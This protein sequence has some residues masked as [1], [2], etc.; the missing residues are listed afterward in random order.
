MRVMKFFPFR[1]LSQQLCHNFLSDNL[2]HFSLSHVAFWKLKTFSQVAFMH[3]ATSQIVTSFSLVGRDTVCTNEKKGSRSFSKESL[4]DS[5][6]IQFGWI[7]LT[8]THVGIQLYPSPLFLSSPP[9][10]FF[11]IKASSFPCVRR[12]EF[13]SQM[14]EVFCWFQSVALRL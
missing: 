9:C 8:S 14:P 6:P 2:Q 10:P 12:L 13:G 5:Y 1:E 4:M 11:P 3:S 7:S